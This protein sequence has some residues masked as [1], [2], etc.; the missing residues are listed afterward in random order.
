MIHVK[1]SFDG[2]VYDT[3]DLY[4]FN[5][6]PGKEKLFQQTF[7]MVSKVRYMK[8]V[9]EN[10]DQTTVKDISVYATLGG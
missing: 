4:T 7:E 1:S 8:V 6:M 2:I 10:S 5:V 9:V 3:A